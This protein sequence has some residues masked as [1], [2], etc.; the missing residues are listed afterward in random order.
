VLMFHMHHKD[1]GLYFELKAISPDCESLCSFI[2]AIRSKPAALSIHCSRG[3]HAKRAGKQDEPCV[4]LWSNFAMP[5]GATKYG[6]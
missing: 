2:S 3:T 6:S 1:S 5:A 4:H